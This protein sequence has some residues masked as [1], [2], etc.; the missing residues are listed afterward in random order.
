MARPPVPVVPR[1]VYPAFRI[2]AYDTP[3]HVR[4][5]TRDGRWHQRADGPTQYLSLH[6]D[7]AWAEYARWNNVRSDTELAELRIAL[8]VV[9][10]NVQLLVDFSDYDFAETSGFPADALVDDDHRR[11]A[12]KGLE[13]RERFAG[14]VAPSAALPGILNVTLFGARTKSPYG[15]DP[16]LRSQIPATIAAIGAPPPN[17]ASRVRHFGDVHTGYED[18]KRGRRQ[19][20]KRPWSVERPVDS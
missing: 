20:I 13:L 8:W 7:G 3:F 18:W 10:V 4:L 19:Q 2:A 15:L 16:H 1:G 14:V 5:N 9:T 12:A 17:L 11:C 6:P